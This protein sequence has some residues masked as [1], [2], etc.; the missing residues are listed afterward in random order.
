[1]TVIMLLLLLL[2]IACFVYQAECFLAVV[3]CQ[4][5]FFKCTALN[6]FYSIFIGAHSISA[7]HKAQGI[8]HS[9][10][11]FC[12]RKMNC[13]V[14]KADYSTFYNITCAKYG[15]PV[16]TTTPS[17]SVPAASNSRRCNGRKP[18]IRSFVIYVE[19]LDRNHAAKQ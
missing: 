3:T 14:K 6:A 1:M 12:K 19:D 16:A 2:L 11:F 10:L 15:A 18:C 17:V 9:I 13:R 5:A 8:E 7:A 4:L